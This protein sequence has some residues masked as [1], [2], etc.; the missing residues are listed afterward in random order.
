MSGQASE[1]AP[2]SRVLYVEDESTLQELFKAVIGAR[3][4]AVDT[5]DTAAGG[6]KM[7]AAEPYDIIA[8]D[9]QLPDKSGLDL[10]KDILAETP[11]V[12]IVLVTGQ[13]SEKIAAEAMSAGVMQYVIK[14]D[15]ATYTN[16]LPSV[17]DNLYQIHLERRKHRLLDQA[18]H[19]NAARLDAIFSVTEEGIIVID[20]QGLIEMTNPA[21]ESIFGYSSDE[22]IGENVSILLPENERSSHEKDVENSEL[23][24]P[25]VIHQVRK[26]TG[27]SKDGKE[28]PIELNITPMVIGDTKKILGVIRDIGLRV[29]SAKKLQISES[30]LKRSQEFAK[31]GTWVWNVETHEISWSNSSAV[32][33]GYDTT[34][35]EITGDEFFSMLHPE[36]EKAMH[37]AVV[38]C[39]KGEAKLDQEIRV[40]LPDNTPHWL[41]IQGDVDRNK[42]GD[43]TQML[44]VM[45]DITD[46]KN[47]ELNLEV[48]EN[49]F[50]DFAT[51]SSDWFWEFDEHDRITFF[52]SGGKE[53]D[54]KTHRLVGK[55]RSDVFKEFPGDEEAWAEFKRLSSARKPIHGLSFRYR[56]RGGAIGWVSVDAK[57]LFTFDGKFRGYR[58]T[59]SEITT[60]VLAEEKLREATKRALTAEKRLTSAIEALDDGF[61]ICDPDDKLVLFN[62]KFKEIYHMVADL[63]VV[64][65]DFEELIRE[66]VKRGQYAETKGREEDMIEERMAVHRKAN[67]EFEQQLKDGRWLKSAERKTPDGDIVSF[68]V[69]ITEL[70]K[71]KDDAEMAN[72][73]KSDFL[74]N[75]SHELRT[76]LNAILGFAQLLDANVK[77]PLTDRQKDQVGHIIKGGRH[78]LELINEVLDLAKIEAGKMAL[79]IENVN[80][81]MLLDECVTVGQQLAINRGITIEERR[82]PDLPPLW[83]DYMR[84][85]QAILNLV[86]NAVKYNRENGHVIIETEQRTE[87]T[88]RISI[89]DTGDGIPESKKKDLFQPFGRLAA[90]NVEVEGTGI[91]LVLTKKLVEE[92]AGEIGFESTVGKGSTFWV[93]F[94]SAMEH[95]ASEAKAE[96]RKNTLDLNIGEENKR[97]LYVED[98]PANLELMEDIATEIPNLTL[99]TSMTAEDGLI[100]VENETF[101]VII[102]DINLPGMNGVKMVEKLKESPSTKDIPVFA[103]SADAMPSAIE[104]GLEAG[105]VDYLTKPIRIDQLVENLRKTF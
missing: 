70:K 7:H 3:G 65:N 57:P 99:V 10:V 97:M 1:T 19:E 103:L 2:Q 55:R 59:T 44:G 23:S 27:Y 31:V 18:T 16:L 33:G 43:A 35:L 82:N 80:L 34:E 60:S 13:G 24:L 79:S 50:R 94:P 95:S 68:R 91:G 20:E 6:L 88:I 89:T 15:T 93:E 58:G 29:E 67:T 28:V 52:S 92:M 64:G 54:A 76:P 81:A 39:L 104:R 12:L 77:N 45:R 56:K 4:F 8:V 71:A 47:A 83:T 75:M 38:S 85:K 53:N 26:L 37:G 62:Q 40:N 69:D 5:A 36:D 32:I 66:G 46:K 74:S 102:L 73:A 86:S 41:H 78:L 11:D 101:D 87:R 105:F 48:S 61:L 63:I 25:R 30:R 72:R 90:E 9:Y 100:K 22:L 21:I 96:I 42:R 84:A 14:S 98:N 49:R 51:V 17:I